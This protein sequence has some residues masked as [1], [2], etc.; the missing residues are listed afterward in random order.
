M[1]KPE[2]KGK[3]G[4]TDSVIKNICSIWMI[5]AESIVHAYIYIYLQSY[6]NFISDSHLSCISMPFFCTSWELIFSKDS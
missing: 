3:I 6:T 1:L 2:A 4:K 5:I